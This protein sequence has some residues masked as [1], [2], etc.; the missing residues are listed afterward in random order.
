M[1]GKSTSFTSRM[2]N[3]TSAALIRAFRALPLI[4]CGAAH[5]NR[6]HFNEMKRKRKPFRAIECPGYQHPLRLPQPAGAAGRPQRGR[7]GPPALPVRR[8]LYR[9]GRGVGM[10]P[11]YGRLLL[12]EPGGDRGHP[13]GADHGLRLD[14]HPGARRKPAGSRMK[15]LRASSLLRAGTCP[16]GPGNMGSFGAGLARFCRI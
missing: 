16:C 7:S 10:A 4:P 5:S 11:P 2:R 15:C 8:H 6:Q 1:T 3:D 13:N 12:P 14:L 9:P